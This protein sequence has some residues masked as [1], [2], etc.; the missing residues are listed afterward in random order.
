MM[1]FSRN[2]LMVISRKSTKGHNFYP[3]GK[4]DDSRTFVI[5]GLQ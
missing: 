2:S 1:Q 3:L 4:P 5:K